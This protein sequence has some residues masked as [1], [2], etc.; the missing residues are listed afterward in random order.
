MM[1]HNEARKLLIEAGNKT[2]NAREIKEGKIVGKTMILISE[3]FA[4]NGK[5]AG[6]V[7]ENVIHYA[8]RK[9]KRSAL[10]K[11]TSVMFRFCNRR[12][13]SC[14]ACSEGRCIKS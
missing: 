12:T 2:H 5:T 9:Q 11:S 3:H 13:C 10:D 4:D 7:I 8:A 6:D 1:L 14:V